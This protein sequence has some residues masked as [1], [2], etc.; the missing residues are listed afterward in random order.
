MNMSFETVL[1]VSAFVGLAMVSWSLYNARKEVR[2][3]THSFEREEWH[4][5]LTQVHTDAQRSIDE[6]KVDMRHEITNLQREVAD[7]HRSSCVSGN[8]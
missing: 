6:L 7:L 8:K 1:M 4:K 5:Q 3:L 2:E